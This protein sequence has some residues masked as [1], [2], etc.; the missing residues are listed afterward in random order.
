MQSIDGE[1]VLIDFESGAYYSAEGAAA[2]ALERIGR[3]EGCER[4]A[5][6]LAGRL[7]LPLAEAEL[8]VRSFLG[9]LVRERLV[10]DEGSAGTPDAD[11]TPSGLLRLTKYRDLEDLLLLDPIHDVSDAGWPHPVPPAGPGGDA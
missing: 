3:G 9:H 11:A 8:H 6:A 4:I 1:C 10:V 5:E 7:G 2:E